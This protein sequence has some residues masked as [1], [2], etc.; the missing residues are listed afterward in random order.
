MLFRSYIDDIKKAIYNFDFQGPNQTLYSTL[1]L[2]Y[3]YSKLVA[4]VS[5]TMTGQLPAS[6]TP[7]TT[8]LALI[9]EGRKVFSSIH[10][11]IHRSFK[12]EIN[13]VYRL[14]SIFL[15]E[16]RYF[17]VLG[18]RNMPTGDTTNVGRSDFIDTLGVIP[19]SDPNIIS[20]AERVI[21]AE[22]LKQDVQTN[23]LTSGNQESLYVATRRYYESLDIPNIDEVLKPPPKPQDIPPIEENALM[24]KEQTPN[25][26]PQQDHLLHMSIHEDLLIGTFKDQISLQT[27][28]IVEFHQKEHLEI[29]RAS[30]RERV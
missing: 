1:G 3:E 19:V 4:S 29:G 16:R 18:D 7:A 22:Q 11:R 30:C 6:D 17:K 9:E 8:V 25:V 28:K 24:I 10:K 15:D 14:N 26:L 20:R 2:L 23:P 13:K 12:K 5:E 27:K 21:K